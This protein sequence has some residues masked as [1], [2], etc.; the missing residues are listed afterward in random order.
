MF[1]RVKRSGQ[2]EYLQ[3]VHN[4]RLDGKVQQRVIATAGTP[5]CAPARPASSMPCWPRAPGSPSTR[6]CSAPSGKAGCQPRRR[7]ESVRRLVFERLWERIGAAPGARAGCWPSGK[8]GFAVE[9]AIFLTVLHRLF[10]SGS[11]RAA[12]V[13]RE[14]Y[15]IP[16]VEEL[17]LHHLYRAMAWLGEPLPE[18]QQA[19]PRPS[20]R[21]A[22]RTRSRRPCSP[23]RAI[24]SPALDWCS[25]TP[26]PSTSRARA[27]RAIG[28]Y[29]HSK[30]HRPDLQA[31]GGGGG[32]RTARGGR[33]AASCGRATRPM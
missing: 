9:R 7:C 30:D 17:E 27:A 4:E 23:G 6:P 31:D 19:G 22:P 5:R 15:A 3:I 11:D 24:C 21:A 25:S 14:H 28:Q 8:F 16:G 2:Y 1:V 26:P 18:D 29:G 33:S 13:W 12:E 32:P 10:A 20:P